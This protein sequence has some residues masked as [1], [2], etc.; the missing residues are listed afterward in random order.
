MKLFLH[1]GDP[2][3]ADP[4]PLAKLSLGQFKPDPLGPK[5]DAAE[6][7]RLHSRT[8]WPTIRRMMDR[9][10]MR[11]FTGPLGQ[12]P[13]FGDPEFDAL[14]ELLARTRP[15]AGEAEVAAALLVW[16]GDDVDFPQCLD[17]AGKL[18][19]IGRQNPPYVGGVT[20]L[21]RDMLLT[22]AR[23]GPDPLDHGLLYGFQDLPMRTQQRHRAEGPAYVQARRRRELDLRALI[24]GGRTESAAR[25]WM[26]RWK[27]RNP[28]KPIP[29]A[30]PPQRCG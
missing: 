2:S 10:K 28:G 16:A 15:W 7:S 12:H 13:Y 8:V 5:I 3:A 17:V 23:I 6:L 1:V 9:A 24:A 30:P 18:A 21:T 25:R 27:Q 22:L 14:D 26:Q 11:Q 19:E 4:D 29:A 20:R